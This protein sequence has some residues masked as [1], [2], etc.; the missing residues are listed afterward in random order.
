MPEPGS[1][2]DWALELAAAFAVPDESKVQILDLVSRF[3]SA[4]SMAHGPTI[5]PDSMPVLII[6]DPG[7]AEEGGMTPP[8][9]MRATFVPPPMER[10]PPKGPPPGR[11]AIKARPASPAGPQSYDPTPAIPATPA[12][13][14]GRALSFD[15]R[16][17]MV[18]IPGADDRN[19]SDGGAT[20][21]PLP[22]EKRTGTGALR[23]GKRLTRRFDDIGMLGSG[24][25]GEVFRVVD[26]DLNRILALKVIRED[27]VSNPRA[28]SR[29]VAEAQVTGQLQHPGIVPVHE[30][31]RLPDGRLYFAMREV[32]GRDF[33]SVIAD[34]HDYRTASGWQQTPTG[35]TFRRL[36]DAFL[37][38]CE[39]MAYAHS[40]NV[41]HRDLKPDNII[42]GEF[43]EV[44]VLDWG[45]ARVIGQDDILDDDIGEFIVTDRTNDD[46]NATVV[47]A[48]AGTPSYMPPEQATGER[49]KQGTWSDVWSLGALLYEILTGRAPYIGR[50]ADHI[51][52]QVVARAPE[53]VPSAPDIPEPLRQITHK[54]LSRDPA[55]RYPSAAEL[56]ADVSQWLE[57]AKR[58]EA[59]LQQLRQAEDRARSIGGMLARVAALRA[60]ADLHLMTV[61]AAESVELKKMA[62]KRLE[63]AR[64]LERGA[65]VL[66]TVAAQLASAALV[67]A[68][69]LAEA[70]VFLA[71]HYQ[72]AHARAEARGN[73]ASAERYRILLQAHDN[74]RH[75]KYLQGD[76][77][78]TLHTDPPFATVEIYRY[79]ERDRR[80]TVEPF[81]KRLTT[82]IN[83]MSL[84]MG[85]YI[86]VIS[87]PGRAPVR[88]PLFI[89][90]EEHWDGRAPESSD[91]HPIY[92]PEY[93]QLEES[94]VYIPAGWTWVGVDIESGGRIPKSRVWIDG[95]V[96]QRD[97]VT[98]KEYVEFLND[99]SR[100]WRNEDA[101]RWAPTPHPRAHAHIRLDGSGHWALPL[102]ATGEPIGRD[103]PV[104]MIDW[105]S[106]V[107]YA[108]WRSAR[109]GRRWQ[110]PAELEWEKAAR[111]VDGRT[112]PFGGWIDPTWCAMSDSHTGPP[113]AF[114]VGDF[115]D[116][117][118]AYGVR[119]MAGNA[120]DWCRDRYT[121]RGPRVSSRG[122]MGAERTAVPSTDDPTWRSVRGGSWQSRAEDCT[123][124]WRHGWLDDE[125]LV[126]IGFRLIRPIRDSGP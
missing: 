86:L 41:I 120:R 117:E 38:V 56:L 73:D 83:A 92:L 4:P 119:G 19:R 63:E 98:C 35:M 5:L 46:I 68:P 48:V 43:G 32:R 25:M 30:M 99:L 20:P 49:H 111:G 80:L 29:F 116:D 103:W 84:P 40:R 33:G 62:W 51:L 87:M 13:P 79:V 109:Q 66:E 16:A 113:S 54:A 39:A 23:G 89:R 64:G 121:P 14:G 90:R 72:R 61:H 102:D 37:K 91:P 67:Q 115:P 28:L 58:R 81:G 93:D 36:L 71:D 11:D 6:S 100:R 1:E 69:D 26:R 97:P 18:T 112:Y 78:F 42:V 70:N 108:A 95:F 34:L 106:A 110:L 85:S 45:L 60:E 31:G 22:S 21:A 104:T 105:H 52:A 8:P 77:A 126:D 94:E 24:G 17:T 57:G 107:A 124:T 88:Y 59:A 50:D 55:G 122:R 2:E 75:A 53:P 15:P 118:S 27:L 76:G 101:Q 9:V 3:S 125:R 65:D 7:L 12:R 82:P 74:G 44:L 10:T 47:G 123:T 96:I 114:A